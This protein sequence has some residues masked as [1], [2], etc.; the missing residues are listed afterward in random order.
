[1]GKKKKEVKDERE[2]KV[3]ILEQIDNLRV[4]Q[5]NHFM[6]GRLEDAISIGEQIIDL[7]RR[8]E[9]P[10]IVEELEDFIETIRGKI[11]EKNKISLVKDA[12]E[13]VKDDHDKFIASNNITD[14][15]KVVIKFKLKFES[16]MDL[17]SIPQI[18]EFIVKEEELWNN[19]TAEQQKLKNQLE[20]LN[21]QFKKQL[22]KEDLASL[23]DLMKKANNLLG[24]L[25]DEQVIALWKENANESLNLKRK[26][27]LSKKIEEFITRSSN[28]KEKFLFEEAI[29]EIDNA[30][31][32][33]KDENMPKSK[34]LLAE[35]KKEIIAGE[36]KYNKLYLKL[37]EYKGKYRENREADFLKAALKNCENIIHIS[38]LIGMKDVELEFLQII[39]QI[40][41]EIEENLS[42]SHNELEELIKR[43]K[44][45]ENL[46]TIDEDTLPIVEEFSVKELLGNL[47]DD[48]KIKLDQ[49]GSLLN[50]YRIAINKVVVNKVILRTNSGEL[51]EDKIP[52]EAFE[53]QNDNKETI[54]KVRSGI[55][56]RL[57]D[58]IENAVI[59]D[60]IPYNFEISEVIFNGDP[61]KELTNKELTKEGV[62][63]KWEFKNLAPK[64][65][66]QINYTLRSRI[67]RTIIIVI[68]GQLKIIKTH[69]NINKTSQ[70]GLCETKIPIT[71]SF[72]KALDG[73][74]I[75]DIIPTNYLHF[76]EE[77]KN[78]TLNKSSE[79]E[80]GEIFK[81]NIETLE[82]RLNYHYKLLEKGQFEDVKAQI[83]NLNKEA[84]S[85]INT[86]NINKALVKYK[87]I[88]NQIINS[89]K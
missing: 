51:L 60:L 87:E 79:L 74:I 70:S 81:W 83:N 18:K 17:K 86:G 37:A 46:I 4:T 68:D 9:L 26:K 2:K 50:E 89:V 16:S 40:R 11:T 80:L 61:V 44:N 30:M 64:E 35:T 43:A 52:R 77:P 88:K 57:E 21:S 41:D 32:L 33:I 38:Q 28:L 24:G 25:V 78:V 13:H 34:K 62:V 45:I 1:L 36:T 66:M 48:V 23:N 53:S 58:L 54:Y 73:I 29:L 75:E 69:A 15:H 8:G 3:R 10:T 6:L 72:G 63:L 55:A 12:F 7:A 42:K 84:E 39:E 56:N 85:L 19:F 14:A 27:D 49:I 22:K 67:S 71:N 76:I 65:K 31:E 59:T 47:S 82:T 5:N 20:K